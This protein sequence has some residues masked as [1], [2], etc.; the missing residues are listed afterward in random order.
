[1]VHTLVRRHAE[2]IHQIVVVVAGSLLDASASAGAGAGLVLLQALVSVS[3]Q[4]HREL[5][6][7]R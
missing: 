5:S 4:M 1:M 7:E 3:V 6:P 2:E